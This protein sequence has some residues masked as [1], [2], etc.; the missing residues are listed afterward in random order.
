MRYVAAMKSENEVRVV[1]A[2]WRPSTVAAFALGSL[3][4]AAFAMLLTLLVV[5]G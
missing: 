2:E 4:G 3:L 1:I 5:G